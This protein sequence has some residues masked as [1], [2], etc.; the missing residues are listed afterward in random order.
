[1]MLVCFG[2]AWPFS[3]YKSYKTRSNKGKSFAFLLIILFGYL[4]GITY[5]TFYNFDSVIYLYVFNSLLVSADLFLF[6]RNKRSIA[7]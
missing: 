4:S 2:A 6:Y 5:K 3:V 7:V 1:M